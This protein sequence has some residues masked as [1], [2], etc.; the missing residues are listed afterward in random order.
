MSYVHE[1]HNHQ[2]IKTAKTI[3]YVDKIREFFKCIVLYI[4]R[5]ITHL[6]VKKK[7]LI[8]KIWL[9]IMHWF[10]MLLIACMFLQSIK[11]PTHELCD[12]TATCFGTK[13]PQHVEADVCH[14][15]ASQSACGGWYFVDTLSCGSTYSNI[16]CSPRRNV[17]C[18]PIW[19]AAWC[20]RKATEFVKMLSGWPVLRS[21]KKRTPRQFAIHLVSLT[22]L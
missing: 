15:G 10:F 17:E 11:H 7:H 5:T 8:Y 6:N 13:F 19:Q 3:S 2:Y 20:V 14:N 1:L 16:S 4:K 22:E 9:G 12:T 21:K 18:A